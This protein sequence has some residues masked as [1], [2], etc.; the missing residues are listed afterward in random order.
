MS[1]FKQSIESSSRTSLNV[2]LR[3]PLTN[4]KHFPRDF[5]SNVVNNDIVSSQTWWINIFCHSVIIHVNR[6][7]SQKCLQ[8]E[9]STTVIFFIFFLLFFIF[10]VFSLCMNHTQRKTAFV[11]GSF[12]QAVNGERLAPAFLTGACCVLALHL[13]SRN[14]ISGQPVKC[15]NCRMSYS[16]LN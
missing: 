5:H 2:G 9:T 11:C 12:I 15:C 1:L 3:W 4:G 8:C 10:F 14:N 7:F 13:E 16:L 6:V